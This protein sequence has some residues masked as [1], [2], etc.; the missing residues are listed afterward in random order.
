M[1]SKLKIRV[2]VMLRNR[3]FQPQFELSDLRQ[4]VISDFSL[5]IGGS[6]L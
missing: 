3:V 1:R 6:S 2:A 4:V 5:Q